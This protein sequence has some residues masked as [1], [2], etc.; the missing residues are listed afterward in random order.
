MG[1]EYLLQVQ[2][3]TKRY[4]DKLAL[5]D[6]SIDIRSGEIVALIGENGAGKT[7]LLNIICG[8]IKP[9][10]GLVQYKGENIFEKPLTIQEFGILI[11]PQFLDYISAE[12]NLRLLSQLANR[13]QDIRIKELL[14]KTELY[15][16]RKKKVKEFSFGMKQRLGLCQCLLTE[17]GFLILD[18]PFVGLDPIGKEI[19]KQTILDIAHKQNVP[20]LFSSHDLDD[21]DEICDRVVMISKGNKQLDQPLEHKQTYTVKTEYTGTGNITAIGFASAMFQMSQSMFI[22]NVILSAIIGRSLASE[23][24]NKSIRLYINRIGIRKLIYEGKELALLI[25]S[26]FIDILLVLTSIVFYYAVL[27]HNPK[28]ASG[29]FYDSNVGMEVAQIICNCIFWLITIFLVM[30]MATRLKTLVCVG[31]YMILYIIMNLMSYIDVIKYLSPLHYIGVASSN[32]SQ[33]ALTTMIFFLYFICAGIL[34][35]HI[36]IRKIEKMD[37]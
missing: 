32:S 12:E 27:V 29:I 22:F 18:E 4:R 2:N 17:V 3:V 20:V 9:S 24:E 23:I 8:Y 10:V 33:I 31:V 26:V 25:F 15:S 30:L 14:E 19:F 28:V 1:K 7:T 21:V 34:F 5:N 11:E 16:S 6:F 36:G 35:T 13:K 37:L